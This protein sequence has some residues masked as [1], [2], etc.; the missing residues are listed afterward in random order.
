ME[1][2]IYFL[3]YPPVCLMIPELATIPCPAWLSAIT[4]AS[5]LPEVP[6]LLRDSLYYPACG[7]NGTPVKYLAGNVHSFVYADYGVTEAQF[8][9][10]LNGAGPD[11]GFKHFRAVV[12]RKLSAEDIVPPGWRP[13]LIPQEARTGWL[14]EQERRCRPFG[15]WSVWERLPSTPEEAG[16]LR[17]SFLY[18]ASEISAAYQGLY[19]HHGVAPMIL[20]IIQPGA[21][22]GEWEA[23]ASNDSFFKHAVR[24]NRGGMPRFLLHGGWGYAD[25]YQTACWSEYAYPPI[26]RLPERHA[27]LWQHNPW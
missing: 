7:L 13:P 19:S 4:P 11:C 3:T 16:P 25:A 14:R 2:K 15:H 9:D 27:G 5:A 8:L 23:T 10:N 1:S 24:S 21:M 6:L 12:Q 26:A 22:G 18:L 20:A 17:F